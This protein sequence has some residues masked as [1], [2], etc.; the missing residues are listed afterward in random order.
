MNESNLFNAIRDID[1][2]K[3][4]QLQ[5]DSV[6]AI[7]DS[8]IKHDVTNTKQI[9]YILATA[10]HES[11]LKPIEEIGKGA[12]KDYGKRLKMGDGPKHRIPYIAPDK[13]YYG[14]GFVQI[15]WYENYEAFGRLLHI[16]L[17]QHPEFALQ[18]DYAA[19]I[20]VIGM[21]KGIFTGVSLSKYFNDKTTDPVNA[22]KIVNGLDQANLIASYYN[23]ILEGLK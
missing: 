18:V 17:L 8:C 20:A 15:T 16:D 2:I 19:D 22:R 1:K 11:R 21:Q 12:G 3:L 14:R 23:H 9:A 6:H 5:V 7:L 13:L 10:Y 4:S